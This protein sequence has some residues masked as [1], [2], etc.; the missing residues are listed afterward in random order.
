MNIYQRP[1][2]PDELMHW[3]IKGMEREDHKYLDRKWVNGRW[4]YIY[5]QAQQTAN[6]GVSQA[7]RTVSNV[8]RHVQRN[9]P[10]VQQTAQRTAQQAQQ[11]I[12]DIRNQ[13]A[14]MVANASQAVSQRTQQVR[15]QAERTASQA[16][17]QLKK[18]KKQTVKRAKSFAH[19]S[20][21]TL[22]KQV[23]K[24][25]SKLEKLI[26]GNSIVT[27]TYSDGSTYRIR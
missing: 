16:S 25:K 9:V 15:Q 27:V 10:R 18:N 6:R 3:G 20:V 19:K 12:N 5:S 2:R 4:Q 11:R 7:R 23:S 21:K 26:Y 14:S 1:L 8:S 17:E 22:K 24:G 13:T